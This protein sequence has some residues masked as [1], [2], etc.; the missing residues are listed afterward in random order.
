MRENLLDSGHC[1][2][3]TNNVLY[4]SLFISDD[5]NRGFVFPSGQNQSKNVSCNFNW[6]LNWSPRPLLLVSYT[7]P[8]IAKFRP[9]YMFRDSQTS[10]SQSQDGGICYDLY[11]TPSYH[12]MYGGEPTAADWRCICLMNDPRLT[13]DITSGPTYQLLRYQSSIMYCLVN[14][15]SYLSL[16]ILIT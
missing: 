2:T 3:L 10:P 8:F 16:T 1:W 9:R 7:S 12:C 11:R 13:L 15:D 4:S 6:Y 5:K 14:Q